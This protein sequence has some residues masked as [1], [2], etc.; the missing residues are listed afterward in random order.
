MGPI[1]IPIYFG[2]TLATKILKFDN[3]IIWQYIKNVKF[4]FNFLLD[5]PLGQISLKFELPTTNIYT[6]IVI[7]DG[8]L[9]YTIMGIITYF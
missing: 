3:F 6:V 8:I 5:A 7:L 2:R 1:P 4:D 9:L